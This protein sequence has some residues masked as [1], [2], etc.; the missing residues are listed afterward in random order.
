MTK[1]VLQDL[2]SLTNETSALNTLN[3]NSAIIE[4][5]SD[6]FLSRDGTTPNQMLADLDMNSKKILNIGDPLDMNHASIIGL[7]DAVALTEPV[8]LNQLNSAILSGGGAPATFSYVTTN[9]EALSAGRQLA[10]TGSGL[11]LT[12][13]GAGNSL[14]VGL[15]GDLNAV[16]SL[17][18]N[19]L[20]TRTTTNTMTTRSITQPAN[21]ITIVNNDG[22]SGNP[23]LSL[24]ND[25]SAVEG[26][27]STGIATRT[28]TDTWTTRTITGTANEITIT[29]GDGVSGAPILSL[30]AA[31]TFTGKT[32]TNGTYSGPVITG[33]LDIQQ[34][35]QLSG[36]ISPSSFSTQQDNYNPVSLATASTLRL[37][38][39]ANSDVTGL[40]GGSDGRLIIIHNIGTTFTIVLKNEN[41]GSTAGNRFNLSADVTLSPGNAVILQYDST[42]SRW[43]V[44]GGTGGGGGGASTSEAYVTI[45]NTAGL[46]SERSLTAGAGI[47]ITD[48]GANTTVTIAAALAPTKQ[49]LLS[50]SSATYTTPA[51][52]RKIIIQAVGAGGGGGG[53]G[54]PGSGGTGGTTTF[55]SINAAGGVG[56]GSSASSFGTGGTGGTGTAD[57]RLDGGDG[58]G[59]ASS[60][61]TFSGGTGGS[62]LFGGAGGGSA[63]SANGSNGK[64]NTGGGG[65]GA[66][67]SAQNPGPG[68]GA[69]QYFELGIVSPSATYTYTIGAGGTAGSGTNT[70][71]VGGTGVII[72]TEYY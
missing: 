21:G 44:M 16:A 66:K 71:G 63:A 1:I 68:G 60:A 45:G 55:N 53:S 35:L 3:S 54:T 59:G 24:A 61:T 5:A 8:T 43:R 69:G 29:N 26:L 67:A 70:G 11:T 41:S 19:G 65:S 28:A 64:A 13:G 48:G 12:D 50:G 46:T 18:T 72:V 10:V 56:G 33:T 7:D 62:S 6:G 30:P 40:S 36:D 57:F 25:L 20:V 32:V 9:H 58:Q 34:N 47:T 23:T 4:T 52:C 39:T 38:S 51:N 31:L 27:S 42:S 37:T 49:Y 2:A 15:D 17:S 22:I 14:T